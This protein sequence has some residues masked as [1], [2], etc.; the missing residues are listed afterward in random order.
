MTALTIIVLVDPRWPDQIPLGIIPYLYGVGSSRL[1]VTPDIPAA[2]RDHYH[3]L[4][5]LPAPSLSQPVARLVI[6]S[7]DAD[8]RLTEPAK[9]AEE[10][11]TRIFRAPSRDDPTWQAQNIMR[12]ALTVGEWEREQTHETLLPYL[13]EETTELAEAIT[14]RADDAELM[15]ELGDVLLQ[16]LFHAEIAARRGA[17]DFGDVVGSFIGKMR[18]RSPYLFDGTTSVVPQSEQKRLWELGK[19]VEGRRVSKGQ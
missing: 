7:D 18:R 4:A 11:T 17:F 8:P 9:T 19:H 15:A 1:E 16:V 3:Q 2:A 12:R 14:T 5:A 13:R 6:T 10:T